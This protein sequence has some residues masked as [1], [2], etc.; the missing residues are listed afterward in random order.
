MQVHSCRKTKRCLHCKSTRA[1][2]INTARPR[3]GGGG[4]L[5]RPRVVTV[6]EWNDHVGVVSSWRMV[7][8]HAAH[9]SCRRFA[10]WLPLARPRRLHADCVRQSRTHSKVPQS[11]QVC[12]TG[13]SSFSARIS[14]FPFCPKDTEQVK[15]LQCV[16][17]SYRRHLNLIHTRDL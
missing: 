2:Q 11:A 6:M 4:A 16:R 3:R 8:R 15:R 7:T 5:P 14:G 13:S 12:S 17:S 9:H 1:Q 10:Q